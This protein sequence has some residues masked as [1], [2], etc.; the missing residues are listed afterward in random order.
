V[1]IGVADSKKLSDMRVTKLAP[2]I[3]QRVRFTITVLAPPRY[4]DLYEQFRREGR[5]LNDL[6]A[7]AHARSLEDLLA[8]GSD[9]AY[10]IVDQFA[11]ARV[12]ERRLLAGTR[13]RGLRVVQ[14]PRAE[15]DVAVAAASILA[16]DEFLRR[17]GG[18]P[19]GGG[20]VQVV[21]AGREIATRGGEGALRRLAKLHFAT[22]AR[23]LGG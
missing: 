16:R 21:A 14:F 15:A 17:L 5:R 13:E 18:L 22:T 3:R 19:K 10:A 9:P 4:N 11:D 20:S 12:I 7:W 6:L 1:D 8:A 23:V 2:Q